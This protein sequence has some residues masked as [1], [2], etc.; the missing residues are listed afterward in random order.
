M[1]EFI[2]RLPLVLLLA[3]TAIAAGAEPALSPPPAEPAAQPAA[4]ATT[5]PSYHLS[6][7]DTVAITV[8]NEPDLTITQTLGRAGEV[9]LYLIGD[10]ILGGKT[11]REGERMLERTY[12]ERQF[13]KDPVVTLAVTT[14]F[15]REVSV[16]GAVRT[17]G[18]VV[19]PRD[20][21]SLDIVEVITRA[22][23][24]MPISKAD[25]VTITR[26][27]PNGKET[28]LTVDLDDVM[29]G[30]RRAGRDRADVPIY[31]GDRI[32][33]PEHLF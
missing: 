27:L 3:A 8:Y 33:I 18:T 12:R 24:F 1:T 29:S 22:G 21:T 6:P 28:V 2:R 11:V 30:R 4:P 31:P 7:G 13:L 16:L 26:R 15:P 10:I 23:G 17:P 14:Y 32:W 25:A 5:D 19:F 9:R 20:T